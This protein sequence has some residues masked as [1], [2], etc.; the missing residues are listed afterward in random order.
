MDHYQDKL[1]ILFTDGSKQSETS[2]TGTALFI[3][4]YHKRAADHFI[5]V[6][7]V[8]LLGI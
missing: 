6:Y 1:F 3:P 8:D 2:R 7:T 5:N 4:H